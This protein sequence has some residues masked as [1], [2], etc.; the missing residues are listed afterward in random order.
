M[1]WIMTVL[2]IT[3]SRGDTVHAA[4]PARPGIGFPLAER[5]LSVRLVSARAPCAAR[6]VCVCGFG[7]GTPG[8]PGATQPVTSH[9]SPHGN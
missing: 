9:S 5:Q 3:I 8:K 7:E 2:R 4:R 6:I 1:N